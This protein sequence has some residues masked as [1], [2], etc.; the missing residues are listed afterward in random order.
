VLPVHFSSSNPIG[1][2]QLLGHAAPGYTCD[3][4]LR[5]TLLTFVDAGQTHTDI[6]KVQAPVIKEE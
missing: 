1:W 3:E 2:S 5:G 4:T 6:A